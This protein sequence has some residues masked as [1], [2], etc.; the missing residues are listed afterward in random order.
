MILLSILNNLSIKIINI[1]LPFH[2][3]SVFSKVELRRL[4]EVKQ[5]NQLVV[6]VALDLDVKPK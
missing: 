5:I 2:Y 1:V 3:F 4:G 6:L